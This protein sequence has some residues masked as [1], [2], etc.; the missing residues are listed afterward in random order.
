MSPRGRY[1]C[2]KTIYNYLFIGD[3][4]VSLYAHEYE[5]V[6][7]PGT[8][9]SLIFFPV[10]ILVHVTLLLWSQ[11]CTFINSETAALHCY[12]TTSGVKIG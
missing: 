12:G 9:V 2:F 6:Q 11:V 1:S 3:L 10:E 5:S 8:R 7:V 4:L